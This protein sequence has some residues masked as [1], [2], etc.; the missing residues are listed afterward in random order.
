MNVLDGDNVSDEESLGIVGMRERA[1][2]LRRIQH[3]RK[4]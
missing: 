4:A 2:L 3:H 1:L